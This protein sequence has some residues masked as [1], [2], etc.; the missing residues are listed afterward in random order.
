MLYEGMVQKYDV[1]YYIATRENICE[2]MVQKYDV[3]Y[4]IATREIEEESQD[5]Q[6]SQKTSAHRTG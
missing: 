3:V 4:Y 6:N 1:V 5:V 2:G